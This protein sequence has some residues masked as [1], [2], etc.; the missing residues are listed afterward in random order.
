MVPANVNDKY[1]IRFC[2][3]AQNITEDDIGAFQNLFIYLIECEFF[4]FYYSSYS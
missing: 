3:V 2:A 4:F 1:V